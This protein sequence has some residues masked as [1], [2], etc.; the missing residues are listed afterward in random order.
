M[1]ISPEN[2]ETRLM[3]WLGI[4][5]DGYFLITFYEIPAAKYAQKLL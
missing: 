4:G 5:N 1:P 3:H 2:R